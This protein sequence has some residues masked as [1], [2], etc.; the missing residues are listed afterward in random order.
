MSIDNLAEKMDETKLTLKNNADNGLGDLMKLFGSV[1]R[2]I[3]RMIFALIRLL[4]F[5]GRVPG[6]IR[7]ELPFYCSVF[8]SNLG[9]IG[10]DAPFHHLYE[11]GTTSMFLAIGK[12]ELKPVID[13]FS[14]EIKSRKMVNL[15]LT[16]DERIC[17]GFY[18]ARSLAKF[19]KYMENP[20]TI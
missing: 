14:G 4:D 5:R 15:N 16:I 2:P 12:S 1:P 13:Q 17:D 10:V 19:I 6:F 18:L 7:N 8:I 20:D 9:S 11:L 3:M